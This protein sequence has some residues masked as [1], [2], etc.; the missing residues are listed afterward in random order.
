MPLVVAA[1]EPELCGRR[2][3]VCG[4]GPVEAAVSV[5]AAL[6]RERPD[7]ILHVG[8][9]G[10][11]R[12]SGVELLD[13]VVGSEA[14][15]EDLPTSASLAPRIALPDTRLGEAALAA[16]LASGTRGRVSLP[17][18]TSAR[19]GGTST[20]G[21]EAMEG[22]AVLRAAA[23]AGVPAVEVR[24]ISNLVDDPRSAWRLEEALSALGEALPGL[25]A[26]IAAAVSAPS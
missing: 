5:A 16:L 4:V 15:Y 24:V 1:T 11:R 13:L 26:S 12:G 8:V 21:V 20:C 3:L 2:G 23:L 9:A 7:A 19:V 6:E 18:G 14:V 22:F 25:V 17:I 10:A